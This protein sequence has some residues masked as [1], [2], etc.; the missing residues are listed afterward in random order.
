[1]AVGTL[2]LK[3]KYILSVIIHTR[4]IWQETNV[5]KAQKFICSEK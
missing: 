3:K 4:H 2:S 5:K 1:M